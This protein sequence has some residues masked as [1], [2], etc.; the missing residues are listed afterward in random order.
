MCHYAW[1]AAFVHQ[2]V[3]D[4]HC[5]NSV[6]R[7]HYLDCYSYL[8]LILIAAGYNCLSGST[9]QVLIDSDCYVKYLVTRHLP[10]EIFFQV[11]FQLFVLCLAL[12]IV[13]MSF[14]LYFC[15]SFITFYIHFVFI[16]YWCYTTIQFY[17]C[18]PLEQTF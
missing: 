9:W 15:Y 6:F 12:L 13:M 17:C 1:R 8:T 14:F 2:P 18:N 10:N 3:F 7:C 4:F 16:S 5:Q 11:W